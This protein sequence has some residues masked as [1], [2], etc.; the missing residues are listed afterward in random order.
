ML[1]ALVPMIV[2]LLGFPAAAFGQSSSASRDRH[3]ASRDRIAALAR[4]LRQDIGI[5][6]EDAERQ[7]SI[8]S[9]TVVEVEHEVDRYLSTLDAMKAD[10]N[11]VLVDLKDVLKPLGEFTEKSLFASIWQRDS[12]PPGVRCNYSPRTA[13]LPLERS[14]IVAFG[15]YK[16]FNQSS[17]TSRAYRA[18]N[19]RFTFVDAANSDFENY[20][21]LS[22]RELHSFRSSSCDPARQAW[23]LMWGQKITANGPSIRMKAYSFD[24][25]KLQTAWGP[26][27]TWGS[28]TVTVTKRGFVVDGEWYK[29]GPNGVSRR[30][31]EYVVTEDGFFRF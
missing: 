19:G 12:V 28:W 25:R 27:N 23:F 20:A 13:P 6:P 17:M 30:H 9:R 21:E 7:L 1:T 4:T 22:T 24:G 14:L 2:L 11:S 15:V 29:P 31:D 10:A 5:H 26:E 16:E 18:V 3:A 8:A